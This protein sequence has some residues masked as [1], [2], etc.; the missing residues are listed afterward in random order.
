MNRVGVTEIFRAFCVSV[1]RLTLAISLAVAPALPLAW[2][3]AAQAQ[4]A[5]ASHSRLV[6]LSRPADRIATK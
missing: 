6:T 1:P 3:S 4:T 2:L 5:L